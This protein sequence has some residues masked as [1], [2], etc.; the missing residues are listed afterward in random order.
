MKVF[1]VLAI[2]VPIIN[3]IVYA[4]SDS[5]PRKDTTPQRL[6]TVELKAALV[7]AR[8]PLIVQ[9][10]GMMIVNVDALISNTGSTALDVL[11]NTPGLLV[12]DEGSITLKGKEGAAVF[13]DGKPSHLSGM[14][15]AGYLRSLPSGMLDRIEIMTNPPARYDASGTGGIINI[16]TKKNKTGGFS[17][18]I[19]GNIGLGV[20]GSSNNNL[21]WSYRR[22][23]LS[24]S[25]NAGLNIGNGYFNSDRVRRYT[26]P[27][28]SPRS[29][30]LEHYYEHFNRVSPGG[31]LG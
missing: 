22:D 4:Q 8:R 5:I 6:K 12:D 13:I 2:C 17:G 14:E 10:A 21:N 30:L 29:S 23:K 20:Y 11:S 24:L 18:S 9:K 7:T 25:G 27:D 3:G 15:L 28:G 26:N 19:T 16:I 31:R 1:F